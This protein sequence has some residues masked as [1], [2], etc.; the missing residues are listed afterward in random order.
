MDTSV[1][2]DGVT[3]NYSGDINAIDYSCTFVAGDTFGGGAYEYGEIDGIPHFA[4]AIRRETGN[5][6]K[7]DAAKNVIY[8]KI[9]V[10]NLSVREINSGG[11][12][13][14]YLDF[15]GLYEDVLYKDYA[16]FYI[17]PKYVEVTLVDVTKIYGE[18]DPQVVYD[19]NKISAKREDG[20]SNYQYEFTC[21]SFDRK[22]INMMTTSQCQQELNFVITREDG[23][24]VNRYK[25][26]G[27]ALN[28]NYDVRVNEE[29]DVNPIDSA[30]LI[31]VK[32]SIQ[33]SVDGDP[34]G[35]G[36]Y[37]IIYEDALPSVTVSVTSDLAKGYEGLA[38]GSYS[39]INN[40]TIVSFSDKLVFGDNPIKY[41][42]ADGSEVVGYVPGAGTY[43]IAMG[44]ITIENNDEVDTLLNY[45]LDFVEGELTSSLFSIVISPIAIT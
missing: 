31:V 3:T 21:N 41:L 34:I 7:F 38:T 32:R 15:Y 4:G 10:G 12:E 25:I 27:K 29:F 11:R 30:Y 19:D 14:Y 16:R 8:Y 1:C 43:V 17:Y 22:P 36:K 42:N 24:F 13:N 39:N 33:L 45:N 23:E 44:E 9:H 5:V 2:S 35:S 18:S 28:E 40:A 6:V 20:V 37:K 26:S